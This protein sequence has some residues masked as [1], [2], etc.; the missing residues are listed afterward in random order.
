MKPGT[1]QKVLGFFVFSLNFM[2]VLLLGNLSR[3]GE[4]A[5]KEW[6]S[7]RNKFSI[8]FGK[9]DPNFRLT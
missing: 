2:G 7:V 3:G 4:D 5:I 1:L 9:W 6:K 8:M